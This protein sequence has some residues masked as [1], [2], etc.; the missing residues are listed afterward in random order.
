LQRPDLLP[1]GDGGS[2]GDGADGGCKYDAVEIRR[3]LQLPST[4]PF[5]NLESGR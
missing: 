5:D 1:G 4:T 2:Q 3:H